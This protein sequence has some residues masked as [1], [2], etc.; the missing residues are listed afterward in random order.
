M[1]L[2]LIIRSYEAEAEFDHYDDGSFEAFDA[3][4]ADVVSGQRAGKRFRILV[5]SN[6]DLARRWNR[7]GATL[8]VSI[9]PERLAAQVLFAGAFSLDGEP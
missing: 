1:K 6:S 8:A 3:I 9:P 2:N 7:P 4:T 5:E